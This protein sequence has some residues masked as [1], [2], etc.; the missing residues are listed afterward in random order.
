MDEALPTLMAGAILVA[1]NAYALTG[2]ADFGGGVWDLLARGPRRDAQRK[3]V[4][5]A[6]GPIW[7]ANHV[8]LILAVVLLFTCFPAA[9]ARLT[10]VLHI[11]FTLV[12]IGIVLR[13][14][15]F[16]FRSYD[17][18]HDA[19][20]R[21]CGAVFAGASVITPLLLGTAIGAI[22]S[23]RVLEPRQGSFA[24]NYLSA[25]LTP[26][27]AMSGLMTL[28]LFAFL[29]ATY[30]TVEAGDAPLADAFRA[31]ALGAITAAAVFAALA[32]VLARG[33]APRMHTGLVRSAWALPL[34]ASAALAAAAAIAALLRRWFR[35]ARLAAAALVSL[36]LWG[37]AAAQFPYI[38]P[39]DLSIA[40]TVSPPTTLRFVLAGLAV[41]GLVL[42]PSLL[43]LFR[44][45][46]GRR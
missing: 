44:V 38:V 41:G 1:L 21:R 46:K 30:L 22:A 28:A 40:G 36:V 7:E 10:T 39:P 8:W 16:T 15:A 43:Y 26:F 37:W 45:F 14:S 25:W 17:S 42:T 34:H 9:F 6:I 5:D 24:A 29:A 32:L 11:P 20:Q 31:R 27:A 3:L 12:L 33:G 23:G 2:G 18:R 19:V 13:G 35:V 4:A